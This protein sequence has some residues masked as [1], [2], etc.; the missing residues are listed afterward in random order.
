[1]ISGAFSLS[2]QAVQLDL[3]PPVRSRQTSEHEGGQVFLPAVN[4]ILFVGVLVVML[5]FQSS[6][7]LATAYGV[8][9]TGALVID[10]ALLLIVAPLL[11]PGE[12]QPRVDAVYP[13]GHQRRHHHLDRVADE[14]PAGG[15]RASR[16]AA[17]ARQGQDLEGHDGQEPFAR[18]ENRSGQHHA[19][20]LEGDRNTGRSDLDGPRGRPG[21]RS[22]R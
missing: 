11:R 22:A 18:P 17:E 7:R 9:V 2:R 1:M 8:S 4:A 13:L 20:R 6:S 15:R 12:D 5:A 16:P 19:Q 10:T 3:L 14:D 21:P